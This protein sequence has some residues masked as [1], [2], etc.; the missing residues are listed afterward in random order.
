[1]KKYNHKSNET[2]KRIVVA[3]TL[4]LSSMNVILL[5]ISVIVALKYQITTPLEIFITCTFTEIASYTGWYCWKSKSENKLK[6]I[7]G[8]VRELNEDEL[9][10]KEEIINNLIS[11]L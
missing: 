10:G 5:I 4:L 1:M 11:N 9:N 8:F 6:I 7:I 3:M 2:T